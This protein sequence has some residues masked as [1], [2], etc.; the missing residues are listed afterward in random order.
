MPV[1][2]DPMEDHFTK[3]IQAKKEHMAKNKLNR[4]QNLAL[5]HNMQMPRSAS[6]HPWDPRVR[7]TWATPCK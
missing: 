4:L 5:S 1:R 6:R 3:M 7:R 2:A